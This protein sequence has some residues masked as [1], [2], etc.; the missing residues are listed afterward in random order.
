MSN[1]IEYYRAR[2]A[3]EL[4]IA[5]ALGQRSTARIHRELAKLY[6]MRAD[7]AKSRQRRDEAGSS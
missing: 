6:Q 1:A 3:R 5:E 7:E 4:E 2:A